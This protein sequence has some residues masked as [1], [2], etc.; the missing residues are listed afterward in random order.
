MLINQV[1]L[2]QILC[3]LSVVNYIWIPVL[4]RYKVAMLFLSLAVVSRRNPG[5]KIQTIDC[6]KEKNSFQPPEWQN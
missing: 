2:P 4:D 1:I 6:E 5:K 3:N